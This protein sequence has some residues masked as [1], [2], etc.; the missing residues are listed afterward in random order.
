MKTG[1]V[2]MNQPLRG[3]SAR[4]KLRRKRAAQALAAGAAIAGGT[5]AYA[6]PVHFNNPPGPDHFEWHG[7]LGTSVWLDVTAPAASQTGLPSGP[8][9]LGQVDYYSYYSRVETNAATTELGVG[10]LYDCFL[11]D[12]PPIH[13][14]MQ[15]LGFDVETWSPRGLI[16]YTGYGSEL[17]EGSVAYL[18]LRFDPG[19]GIHYG[20][21]GVVRDGAGL[22][23]WAWGY[24]TDP[25]PEPGT[26]SMLAVGAAAVAG[27]R[28][29]GR[30]GVKP[31]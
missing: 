6:S 1:F 28:R 4:K 7:A 2:R 9:S 30:T 17:P 22:D 8:L 5:Q 12:A 31:N 24:D 23:A 18:A 10:G 27:R 14:Y 13:Y 25:V 20:W 21:V 16:Y 26:F 11:I 19:D 29:P 3:G 15:F